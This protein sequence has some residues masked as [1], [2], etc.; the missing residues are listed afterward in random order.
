[1]DI[2]NSHLLYMIT[3]LFILLWIS[4]YQYLRLDTDKIGLL[5]KQ[6]TD[7][8]IPLMTRAGVFLSLAPYPDYPGYYSAL[9]GSNEREVT[10]SPQC[11]ASSYRQCTNNVGS[12]ATRPEKNI[13]FFERSQVPSS[14]NK[15]EF[16]STFSNCHQELQETELQQI[17]G[18]YC[19][20][21]KLKNSN[22]DSGR[23]NIY[24]A[25]PDVISKGT[26]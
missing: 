23:I 4:R 9:T 10:G 15:C 13:D 1:M 14:D 21:E 20:I 6:I 11:P 19:K 16:G 12:P 17:Q 18:A 8:T 24:D 7:E 25:S 22:N 3:V 2:E 26:D 5:K